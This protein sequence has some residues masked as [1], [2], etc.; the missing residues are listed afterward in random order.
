MK[1]VGAGDSSALPRLAVSVPTPIAVPNG[2][3]TQAR[4]SNAVT[5]QPRTGE[6]TAKPD[7]ADYTFTTMAAPK[8]KYN[9]PS[10]RRPQEYDWQHYMVLAAQSSAAVAVAYLFHYSDL[11]YL[12]GF[13]KRKRDG[14]YGA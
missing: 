11:P 8:H 6:P 7:E 14:T 2:E 3:L 12:L 1:G 10:N 4:F 13:T 9:L 5:D